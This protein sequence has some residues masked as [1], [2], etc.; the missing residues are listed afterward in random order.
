MKVATLAVTAVLLA[1]GCGK[2]E[3]SSWAEPMEAPSLSAAGDVKVPPGHETTYRFGETAVKLEYSWL[4]V[5]KFQGRPALELFAQG[6]PKHGLFTFVMDIPPGTP[7]LASLEGQTLGA[8]DTGVSFGNA[9]DM[10]TGTGGT[11]K[12]EEVTPTYVAGTF[13]A[14]ACPHGERQCAMPIRVTNGKFK[15]FRSALSDDVTFTRYMT[16]KQ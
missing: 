4:S 1:T 16:L 8:R 10:A 2:S 3:S 12:I 7:D 5:L 9:P 13:D 15:A 6:G 14:Q 11:M